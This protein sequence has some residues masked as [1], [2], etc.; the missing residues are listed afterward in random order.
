MQELRE[1]DLDL[2]ESLDT[3]PSRLGSQCLPHFPAL[4]KSNDRLYSFHLSK[5]CWNELIPNY[6]ASPI[7]LNQYGTVRLILLQHSL[8]N[9]LSL[10]QEL[11][12]Y[13]EKY[14]NHSILVNSMDLS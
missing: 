7:T 14:F 12:S 8:S 11:F 10:L 13:F 4:H 6:K 3:T 2:P 5:D 1:L 9:L